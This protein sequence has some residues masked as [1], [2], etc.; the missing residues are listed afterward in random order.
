MNPV[1]AWMVA[2]S[3]IAVKLEWEVWIANEIS[4]LPRW[5]PLAHR[6]RRQTKLM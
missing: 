5:H 3:G 2:I 1:L 4:G 6:V